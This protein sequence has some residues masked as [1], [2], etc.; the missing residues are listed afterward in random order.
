[1]KLLI[2]TQKVNKSDPILGF[3]HRW[4][5]EFSTKFEKVT[6]ICLEEG[7]HDLPNNV[8]VLSL[9]KELGW[10]KFDQLVWFYQYIWDER[11]DYEAVFVHM[12]QEY[13]L[14][15][16]WFW[17]LMGKKVA[18]WRNHH[19]GNLL[20]HIAALFPQK[21]F[22]T[23]KFSFTAQYEKT[24]L[25]PVGIDTQVFKK[26]PKVTR[27]PNSILFIGRISSSKRVHLLIEALGQLNMKGQ[28]FV[29]TIVGDSL[30]QDKKYYEKLLVRAEELGI[31][32]KISFKPGVSN[33]E[34][35]KIYN[36]HEICV[37]L[38][39]SGM[40]DK[41]IFEAALCGALSLSSNQNLKEIVNPALLF[42]EKDVNDLT[43]KLQELMALSESKKHALATE[44]ATYVQNHHSLESLG[45]KLFVEINKI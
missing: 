16:G 11:G 26:L 3:F 18:L 30:P 27:E 37:N 9:G 12:N 5:E 44:F 8:K 10:T 2:I 36:T 29:A 42:A 40:Y 4:I 20:T 1:M 41:T 32:N 22:C 34:T 28:D 15:A 7:S 21:V 39:S 17:R 43:Y 13:L 23:S 14:L 25:M 38:S 24:V 6:V 33:L 45:E 35:P 19:Q 31:K